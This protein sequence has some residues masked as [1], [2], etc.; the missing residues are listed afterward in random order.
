MLQNICLL[1]QKGK[2]GNVSQAQII[3]KKEKAIKRVGKHY[4]RAITR[5]SDT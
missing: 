4:G 5:L 1:C 2:G 3:K